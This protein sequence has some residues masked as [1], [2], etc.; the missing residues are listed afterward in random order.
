MHSHGHKKA[1]LTQETWPLALRPHSSPIKPLPRSPQ[2]HLC[3]TL[4][5][6]Q[7]QSKASLELAWAHVGLK[8]FGKDKKTTCLSF[9]SGPGTNRGK[10][11]GD[12]V[13][14][15]EHVQGALCTTPTGH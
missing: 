9:S 1:P 6:K 10:L 3:C 14:L 5:P 11:M 13:T 12:P 8:W 7:A 4:S 15:P 2:T